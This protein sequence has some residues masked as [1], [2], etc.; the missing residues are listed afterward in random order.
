MEESTIY[1]E[2]GIAQAAGGSS[3]LLSAFGRTRPV[4]SSM[5]KFG[6]KAALID[7]ARRSGRST[8]K[9][10]A[11]EVFPCLSFADEGEFVAAYE[12]FGRERPRIVV[13]GH[14]KSVGARA[15]DRE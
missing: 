15:H 8:L 1:A 3:S 9:L 6:G 14:D 2:D 10:V 7:I 12:R 11:Y 13:R 4:A 5:L